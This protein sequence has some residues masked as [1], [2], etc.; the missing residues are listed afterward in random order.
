MR[1]LGWTLIQY[2]WCHTQGRPC[3]D[4]GRSRHLQA[5][6]TGLRRNQPCQ[7]L[8]LTSSLQNCKNEFLL[9]QSSSLSYFTMVILKN[10]ENTHKSTLIQKY[11][12]ITRWGKK[13]KLFLTVKF[14]L[15]NVEGKMEI[16]TSPFGRYYRN[17]CFRQES[18]LN[19]KIS[20][21]RNGTSYL[22]SFRSWFL[23]IAKGKIVTLQ[24]RNLADSPSTKW[25]S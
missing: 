21:W 15:I 24:W 5:K 7:H 23:L 4:T 13:G 11:H 14:Q 2:D 25:E 20:V 1:P 12:W 3:Q 6:K 17:N 10:Y 22:Y 16:E 19:L 18:S 8:V 9:F